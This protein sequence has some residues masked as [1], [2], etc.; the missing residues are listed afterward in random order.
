[1]GFDG[2]ISGRGRVIM[3]G[4]CGD[5]VMFYGPNLAL[6]TLGGGI[7]PG[8][9]AGVLGGVSSEHKGTR[10]PGTHRSTNAIKP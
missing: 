2:V 7:C 4:V 10:A 8:A 1:M 9:W 5:S 3:V 6:Y